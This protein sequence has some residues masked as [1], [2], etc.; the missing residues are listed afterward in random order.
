M[1]GSDPRITELS[2]EF[3]L[4]RRHEPYTTGGPAAGRPYPTGLVFDICVNI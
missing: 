2:R 4:A 3:E 1:A